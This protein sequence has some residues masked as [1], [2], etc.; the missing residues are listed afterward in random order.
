VLSYILHPYRPRFCLSESK[1]LRSD[2]SNF[3]SK[4]IATFLKMKA[5]EF[6]VGSIGGAKSLGGY[7]VSKSVA[8]MLT[9]ELTQPIG[10]A[11][12][13]GYSMMLDEPGRLKAA[14]IKVMQIISIFAF[15]FGFGLAAVS[16]SFISIVFGYKWLHTVPFLKIFA[17][18]GSIGA[19]QSIV[20]PILIAKGKL[21]AISIFTWFNLT[22]FLVV[23]W[24]VAL[25]GNLYLIVQTLV[26]FDFFMLLVCYAMIIKFVKLSISDFIKALTRPFIS[27]LLMWYS[28]DFF[29]RIGLI[30]HPVIALVCSVIVGAL[31]F[32]SSLFISWFACGR[33]EGA[34]KIIFQK[35]RTA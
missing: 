10:N 12:L 29:N 35:L 19:L 16:E 5:D 1:E 14:F 31:I 7:Y 15:A 22:C 3:L 25:H 30:Q 17:I 27:A 18:G 23:L 32:I 21:K 28:I 6:V 9:V 2:S 34:E 26:I 11:L 8:T 20:S 13:P 33:P 4:N 24:P